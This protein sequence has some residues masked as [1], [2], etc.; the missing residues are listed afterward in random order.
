M[1]FEEFKK[2]PDGIVF[3]TGVLPNSEEGIYM[4]NHR[5]G[6]NMRWV[7]KKGDF[8]DWAVYC[9]WADKTVEWVTNYGDKIMTEENIFKC[10]PADEEMIKHYRY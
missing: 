8:S 3:M 1:T 10:V 4:T 5:Y 9:Y 6:D 7:A 2:V